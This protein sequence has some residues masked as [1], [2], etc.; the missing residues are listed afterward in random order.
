MWANPPW[1]SSST[2][3]KMA[4]QWIE[5]S[6]FAS[7]LPASKFTHTKGCASCT[8]GV[9]PTAYLFDNTYEFDLKTDTVLS[10]VNVD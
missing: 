3:L 6:I 2:R 8:S 5:V 4:R 1:D 9:P 7:A 10:D